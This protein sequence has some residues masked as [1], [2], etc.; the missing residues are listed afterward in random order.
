MRFVDGQYVYN[1]GTKDLGAGL[2]YTIVIRDT[3][4][5]EWSSAPTLAIAIIEAKR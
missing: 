1:L 5:A 3:T 4:T 2:V